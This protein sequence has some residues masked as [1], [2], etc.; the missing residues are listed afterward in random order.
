VFTDVFEWLQGLVGL[1][2]ILGAAIVVCALI[3]LFVA[4]GARLPTRAHSL[5]PH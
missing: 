5:R 2:P 3:G 1:Y 4:T